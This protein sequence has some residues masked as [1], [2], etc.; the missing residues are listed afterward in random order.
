MF[1]LSVLCTA[2]SLICNVSFSVEDPEP[3]QE[4]KA[5][6]KK[7]LLSG[8]QGRR[9]SLFQFE[10]P[11]VVDPSQQGKEEAAQNSPLFKAEAAIEVNEERLPILG[12]E[13]VP[14]V[15]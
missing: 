3:S 4:V 11:S 14:I 6:E 12:K 5:F 9:N 2:N 15:P 8:H 10:K 1:H 13:D 7:R